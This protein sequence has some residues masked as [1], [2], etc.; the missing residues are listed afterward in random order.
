MGSVLTF[1]LL[2]DTHTQM[3]ISHKRKHE[4]IVESEPFKCD[5]EIL[6]FEHACKDHQ[7]LQFVQPW[8]SSLE[9]A[10]LA[11]VCRSIRDKIKK[12]KFINYECLARGSNNSHAFI[13][14][15][16]KGYF[17][18]A[19]SFYQP[20][21]TSEFKHK[22]Q[23]LFTPP[24]TTEDFKVQRKLLLNAADYC[25]N[26]WIPALE[27]GNLKMLEWLDEK[28]SP[29][30]ALNPSICL[31]SQ[32]IGA[33]KWVLEKCKNR[34]EKTTE[35]VWPELDGLLTAITRRCSLDIIKLIN[36][37]FPYVPI[38]SMWNPTQP[39]TSTVDLIFACANWNSLEVLQ[40]L[41][42]RFDINDWIANPLL[43]R[44]VLLQVLARKCTQLDMVEYLISGIQKSFD[45]TSAS[46]FWTL[47]FEQF[48][49]GVDQLN[50]SIRKL[51][52]KYS[53]EEWR[54]KKQELDSVTQCPCL[55][56][57]EDRC[58]G[59]K[60]STFWTIE[61][62]EYLVS[63]WKKNCP[64]K[65]EILPT[66]WRRFFTKHASTLTSEP[67]ILDWFLKNGMSIHIIEDLKLV[68]EHGSVKCLLWMFKYIK[69]KP[70]RFHPKLKDV[71]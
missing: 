53:T 62:L 22:K 29:V 50:F 67:A 59:L 3:E 65:S 51:F 24:H 38:V 32:N 41:F 9:F 71:E 45:S 7:L 52:D 8:I 55:M 13:I 10:V 47:F 14:A 44:M 35:F 2:K 66:E 49:Q 70:I 37:Y 61:E 31:Q 39:R 43:I 57:F 26:W 64:N 25:T 15:V 34:N 58:E 4:T 16:N 63:I 19:T 33:I 23:I 60:S 27:M 21:K 11:R 1:F 5:H 12:D 69:T 68:I 28:G 40:W 48:L 18:V 42:V 36:L 46:T 56:N 20:D 6:E 54:L 30:P 17:S